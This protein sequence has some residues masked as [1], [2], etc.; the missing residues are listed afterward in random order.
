MRVLDLVK[1]HQSVS[2][3][4]VDKGPHVAQNSCLFLQIRIM[5]LHVQVRLLN[6]SMSIGVFFPY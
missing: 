2:C 3:C 6:S 1:Q 4:A 5:L